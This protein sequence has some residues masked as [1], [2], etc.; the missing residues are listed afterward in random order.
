MGA[1]MARRLMRAGHTCVAYDVF[2][3]SVEKLAAEGASGA[4]SVAELVDKLSGPRVL[5]MMVPAANV[6]ATIAQ[7]APLLQPGDILIDGGNSYYRDDVERAA[8][9][10]ERGIKYVDCGTSG[11]VLGLE[12]GYCLMIGGETD[13]VRHLDPIFKALAPGMGNVGATEGAAAG[14]T[15]PEGYLHCGASGAGHFVKMVHNGI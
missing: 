14:S 12:R 3:E 8:K 9:L 2:P 13:V 7:F 6:D 11:G 5:W 10:A 1:N 4:K 15:A